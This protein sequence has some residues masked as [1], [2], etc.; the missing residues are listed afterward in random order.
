MLSILRK[1]SSKL[2]EEDGL[3]GM[4]SD[5][6]IFHKT[7]ADNPEYDDDIRKL[8]GQGKSVKEIFEGLVVKD[9][10]MAAHVFRPLYD[11]TNGS[12]GHASIEVNPHL[13]RQTQA[14]IE[15]APALGL[16]VHQ[17]EPPVAAAPPATFLPVRTHDGPEL[18]SGPVHFSSAFSPVTKI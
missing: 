16:K 5:P 8:K 4:T 7:I 15:E 3:R 9:V 18:R 13:V 14:T 11:N 10:Q 2:I 17:S 1:P 6:T 12:H